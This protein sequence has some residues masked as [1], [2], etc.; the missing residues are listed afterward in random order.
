M[1]LA[2]IAPTPLLMAGSV[3]KA[4]VLPA[5][6]GTDAKKTFRTPPIRWSRRACSN[7]GWSQALGLRHVNQTFE[8]VARAVPKQSLRALSR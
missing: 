7:G 1:C 5:S 6:S 4:A 3:T 8:A 2:V